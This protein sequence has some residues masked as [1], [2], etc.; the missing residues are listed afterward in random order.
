[1]KFN[2]IKNLIKKDENIIFTNN[3]FE[4]LKENSL[5]EF[6]KNILMVQEIK[7][8]YYIEEKLLDYYEEL[9]KEFN[10][11]SSLF[12]IYDFIL[13]ELNN[14]NFDYIYNYNKFNY[15]IDRNML[16]KLQD[17][18]CYGDRIELISNYLMKMTSLKIS[19][20]VVDGLF[21]DTIY[22]VWINIKEMLRY[23]EKLDINDNLI[24]NDRIEFYKLI[25]NIDRMDC[26]DKINL[27]YKL[28]D[29]NISLMFYNDLRKIKDISFKKINDSLFKFDSYLYHYIDFYK[30]VPIYELD[31]DS[32]FM[33]V[34]CSNNFSFSSNSSRK[35][36]SLISNYNMNVF[37]KRAFIYGY[38]NLPN[39]KVLHIFEKDAHSCRGKNSLDF[40][41]NGVV[42]RIM[43][44]NQ[45]VNLNSWNEIQIKNELVKDLYK[46][47]VPDFLVVFDNITSKHLE[48]AMRL[49]IPIV[50]ID[51]NKYKRNKTIDTNFMYD[52]CS[53][54]KLYD[55][56]TDGDYMEEKRKIRRIF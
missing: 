4:L 51:T 17:F 45:I 24:S 8:N 42:N 56:Y 27:F 52:S 37:N 2:E 35:C 11:S 13:D 26:Y 41:Y 14:N 55:N 34:R 19:E 29:K 32:F 10:N 1:M 5:L 30:E 36:Y 43:Y 48:E 21:G 6:R 53:Y 47:L 40:V 39:D 44:V 7:P 38:N 3:F 25:L 23:Y 46:P 49:N 22:N 50:R 31:G 28:R 54:E 18:S 33:L 16:L 20:I 9:L 15:F 12:K